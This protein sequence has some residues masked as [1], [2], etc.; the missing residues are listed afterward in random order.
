MYG[1]V[2]GTVCGTSTVLNTYQLISLWNYQAYV[3]KTT[4][5]IAQA[6]I[7]VVH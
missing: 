5:S 2:V 6:V 1:T 7:R 3:S 4:I